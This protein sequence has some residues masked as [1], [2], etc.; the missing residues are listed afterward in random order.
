MGLKFRVLTSV[1]SLIVYNMIIYVCALYV[2]I[3]IYQ[4]DPNPTQMSIGITV[5]FS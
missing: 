4:T 3:Y 1:F 5:V 2:Y